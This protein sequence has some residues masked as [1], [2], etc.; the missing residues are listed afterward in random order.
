[1]LVAC[2]RN[3]SE[4]HI[5]HDASPAI[6]HIPILFHCRGATQSKKGAKKAEKKAAKAEKKAATQQRVG[7]FINIIDHLQ[8]RE[9]Q[10]CC[11]VTLVGE[12]RESYQETVVS[13]VKYCSKTILLLTVRKELIFVNEYSTLNSLQELL[14][15]DRNMVLQQICAT[16]TSH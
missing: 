13:D 5:R 3:F 4:T 12:I 6:H 16:L 10:P 2:L 7:L 9:S 15:I 8:S 1:M 14:T 11:A